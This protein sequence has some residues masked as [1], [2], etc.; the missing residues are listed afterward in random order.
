MLSDAIL[1]PYQRRR[2]LP[3]AVA[4]LERACELTD[5]FAVAD[6]RRVIH[7]AATQYLILY[8]MVDAVRRFHESFPHIAAR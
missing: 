5:L 7:V 8:V 2:F 1:A 6:T 4:F 3:Y